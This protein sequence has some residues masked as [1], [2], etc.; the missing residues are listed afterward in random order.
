[1]PR[2]IHDAASITVPASGQAVFIFPSAVQINETWQGSVTVPNAVLNSV[3]PIQ[4]DAYDTPT[5]QALGPVLASW[6]NDQSS[7]PIQV[8]NRLTVIG[9]GITAGPLQAEFSGASYVAP[10]MPP[11]WWPQPT[12]APPPS[13]PLVLYQSPSAGTP[14]PAGGESII[15]ASAPVITGT[16]LTVE[17][18]ATN[19]AG[20]RI[21]VQWGSNLA[22]TAVKAYDTSSQFPVEGWNC[23]NIDTPIVVSLL[24]GSATN[25]ATMYVKITTGGPGIELPPAPFCTTNP[26]PAGGSPLLRCLAYKSA[27]FAV[28]NNAFALPAY[29]GDVIVAAQMTAPAASPLG[30]LEVALSSIDYLGNQ[31]MFQDSEATFQATTNALVLAPTRMVL[32][33]AINSITVI[34]RTGAAQSG[35][36]QVTCAGL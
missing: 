4:W 15:V 32:P 19:Q 24:N 6:Y 11:P 28:G 12:P 21:Y 25:L 27:S 35:F 26:P 7:G 29:Y 14:V 23:I 10:E 17:L 2:P 16:G 1:M 18:F 34:N 31:V 33:R 22:G 36:F 5:G 13:I 8:R 30:G 20:S 9:S 3:I